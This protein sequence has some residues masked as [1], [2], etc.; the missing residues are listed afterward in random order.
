VIGEVIVMRSSP[1]VEAVVSI[2]NVLFPTDFSRE[3]MSALPYAL[4]IAEKYHSKLFPVHISAE[5]AGLPA[6]LREGLGALGYHEAQ[7][8][9]RN[10]ALLQE[11]LPVPYEILFR[12]GEI[13]H[14]LSEI[15][16]AKHMDLIVTGTHGRSGIGKLVAGS[17]AETI[18]RH[19]PCPVLTV[20]PAVSGEPDS[21]AD[22]HEIL[23]ATDFSEAS[24]VALPYA[25]SLAQQNGA[26]LYL[27]HV[28]AN[29]MDA[30]TEQL[31][32]RKLLELVAGNPLTCEPRAFIC[33]GAAS[34]QIV[35]FADE[36]GVDL[37]VMGVRHPPSY[38]ETSRHLRLA[39]AYT[40]AS[41]AVCPL[42]SV[43]A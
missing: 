2:Q 19:A 32:Q 12:R 28:A 6:S 38:F 15:I 23:L 24:L 37:V 11:K 27:L 14:E 36:M 7:D 31:M 1:S 9:N 10:I 33:Y 35:D 39:T 34:Q 13:W 40:V 18:F 29:P 42:L 17:V 25:V 30:L 3:S 26:R 21:I 4:A 8:A 16:E 41:R 22:L 5:P 20:G 43:R